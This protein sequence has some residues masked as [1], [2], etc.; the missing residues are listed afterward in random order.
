MAGG[1]A[2]LHRDLQFG[3]V[4]VERREVCVQRAELL[5]DPGKVGLGEAGPRPQALLDRGRVGYATHRY[6]SSSAPEDCRACTPD[7]TAAGSAIDIDVI[8]R[9]TRDRADR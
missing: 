8:S 5:G 7:R 6:S 1:L 2:V 9:D 3:R 4:G